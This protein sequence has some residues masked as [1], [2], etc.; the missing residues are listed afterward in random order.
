MEEEEQRESGTQGTQLNIES[1]P[2]SEHRFNIN[3]IQQT[4]NKES[5]E[6][7][8]IHNATIDIVKQVGL[9]DTDDEIIDPEH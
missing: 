9:N 6:H 2:V 4:S 7:G 5:R 3:S 1:K 8:R